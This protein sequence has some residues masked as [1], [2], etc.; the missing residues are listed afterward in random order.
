MALEIARGVAVERG[1][2]GEA[3]IH[4][5]A[6]DE[7]RAVSLQLFGPVIVVES[8]HQL[9]PRLNPDLVH[10]GH[11]SPPADPRRTIARQASP[12][13]WRCGFRFQ[14]SGAVAHSGRWNR[15]NAQLR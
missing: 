13:Q 9:F 12:R 7:G 2:E 8:L 1:R 10:F 4:E 6:I 11:E 5:P 14:T 3:R 15:L